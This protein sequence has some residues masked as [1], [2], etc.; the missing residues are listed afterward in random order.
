MAP[1][2]PF[3]TAPPASP[4]GP[5]GQPP[6]VEVRRARRHFRR[7]V[8][9]PY[10]ADERGRTT[11]LIGGLTWRH[12]ELVKAVFESCGHRCEVL[13]PPN[14]EAFQLGKDNCN[15][16]ECNPTY[17]TVGSLI[18]YLKRMQA[19]GM[20]AS[21]ITDRFVHFTV[22]SC[23]PCRHGMYEAEYRFALRNAGFEGFRIPL[24]DQSRGLFNHR[25]EPGLEYTLDFA[26]WGFGAL[27]LA[28]VLSDMLY[29][30]RPFEVNAGET[31]RVFQECVDRLGGVLRDRRPYEVLDE[32]GRWLASPLSL[33][34][35]IRDA[36]RAVAKVREHFW[37]PTLLAALSECRDRVS[38]IEVDRLRVKPVV[39]ITGE[40]YSQTT[41][42]LGNYY[43]FSFLEREGAQA[44]VESVACWV[45]YLLHQTRVHWRS[46]KGLAGPFGRPRPWEVG[47][48]LANRL[49]YE[50]WDFLF[51]RSAHLYGRLYRRL[52]RG[53]GDLA[54]ELLPHA[55]M[56]RLA[57]PFYNTLIRG[58]EGHQEVG[59]NIYYTSHKLSHMVLSLKPFGCMPSQ[60][61]DG[62]QSAVVNRHP[63]MIFLPVETSGDGEVHAHSRVQMALSEAK[64]RAKAEFER[65]LSS[66]GKTLEQIRAY[67]AAHPQLRSALYRV[68]HRRGVAG[69]AASYLLHVSDLMD[70][71][72]S[73]G[74]R[75]RAVTAETAR[76]AWASG[77]E[78]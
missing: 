4:E 59:K 52:V 78:A 31:D 53:L 1:A 29:Q 27:M 20:S 42:S 37:S 69:V 51:G 44:Q 7:P 76:S 10:L 50:W 61:S 63:E 39:K 32:A 71:K 75:R 33:H 57:H 18:Q 12:H 65:A 22:G 41:E 3:A 28:D 56:A 35:G 21:E 17:F 47:K 58:G 74:R 67:A 40:F 30:I 43:M 73:P 62:V 34:T 45:T 25:E 55:E 16:G 48:R 23:G 46:R 9:R 13:P 5:P 6:Q 70:A 36:V 77:A 60:L 2:S 8:E 66:T 64:A 38:R 54:H 11:V 15:N 24:L 26:I 72:Q 19:T 68:P 14:L 49:H